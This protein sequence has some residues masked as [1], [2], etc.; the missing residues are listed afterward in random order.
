MNPVVV[1]VAPEND[2]H[3]LVIKSTLDTEH[4]VEAVIWDTSRLPVNDFLTFRPKAAK[5]LISLNL[6]GRELESEDIYSIWWRRPNGFN[7][8]KDIRDEKI[9]RFCTREYSALLHGALASLKV[10]I[11]NMPHAESLANRKA[12]QLTITQQCGLHTPNTLISN[13]PEQVEEFWKQN[14]KDCIYKTLTPTP[15]QFRETRHLT[16]EDLCHLDTLRHAPIIVQER[17]QGLDVRI[18]V[19]GGKV[20]AA[21][22]Q[23]DLPEAKTD[24]RLDLTCKW[25]SYKLS[26]DLQL[27]LRSFLTQLG[28]HYGCIDMRVQ[29]DGRHIFLE[30]N[31]S[32][33]FLFV[34]VDTEQPLANSFSHLLLHPESVC[35]G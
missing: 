24:W 22:V 5:G 3:A 8:S 7:L 4:G 26:R 30:V 10:P 34:E 33:Q 28:L 25:E 2:A 19:F 15:D 12:F 9:A 23:S 17:I 14:H 13:D 11:V 16:E 32:G 1:I 31:P 21:S 29:P 18:N 20:F 27:Q 35:L 6:S